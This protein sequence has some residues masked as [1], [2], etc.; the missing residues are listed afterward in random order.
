VPALLL[1]GWRGQPGVKDE[2]QHMKQGKIT[3]ALLAALDIPFSILSDDDEQA[4]D[5][6]RRAVQAMEH[7]NAPYALIVTRDTFE[8]YVPTADNESPFP[9]TREE[10]VALVLSELESHDVVVATTGKLG[11]ELY[12]I[13][14]ATGAAHDSDFL[15][16]GSLGHASQ[17]ALTIALHKPSR[18]VCCFD[19]DGALLMHMGSLALIGT[20]TA[21][22]LKHI[23]YNNA[24]HDSVGGQPTVG[25]DVD[26][27]AIARACGYKFTARAATQDEVLKRVRELRCTDGPGFLEVRIRKGARS[28]LGRPSPHL[29][30]AKKSFMAFLADVN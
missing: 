11:R 24:A 13:R 23:V 19:G 27:P 20:S 4:T 15:V 8:K 30:D 1:I 26:L 17:V 22:N 14:E 7:N 25:F 12:A 29:L 6:V 21:C 28:N 3:L 18:M 10:A 5:D 16:V 2:P 9:L